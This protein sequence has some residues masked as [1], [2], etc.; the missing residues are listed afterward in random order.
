MRT[1][2]IKSPLG[3][4]ERRRS[5]G[6]LAN[7]AVALLVLHTTSGCSGQEAS[8]P[9]TSGTP[10]DVAGLRIGM[11]PSQV[12]EILSQDPSFKITIESKVRWPTLEI[13]AEKKNEVVIALFTETTPK[14]WFVGRSLE[15]P[16]NERPFREALAN[17]AIEKYGKP[18]FHNVMNTP[19]GTVLAW[20]WDKDGKSM[21]V[22]NK[23]RS[24]RGNESSWRPKSTREAPSAFLESSYDPT[25]ETYIEVRIQGE[26]FTP[27]DTSS[28]PGLHGRP[29]IAAGFSTAI[30][31]AAVYRSDPKNPIDISISR[32]KAKLDAASKNKGPDL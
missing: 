24:A 3:T 29:E 23:C 2:G 11:T 27:N 15:I 8:S 17:K 4:Q 28:M 31:S 21:T 10:P 12:Q 16:A 22:F 32:E 30:T 5:S 26:I 1:N 19:I 6:F 14:A 20:A 18:V 13:V 25:C 7:F 9:N